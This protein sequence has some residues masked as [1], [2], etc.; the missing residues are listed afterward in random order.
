MSSAERQLEDQFI[1]KLRDLKY[2]Y[3]EDIHDRAALEANFREKFQSLNQVKL[4]DTEFQRLLDESS[5]PTSSPP[6]ARGPPVR[7]RMIWAAR[8]TRVRSVH[9]CAPTR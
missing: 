8:W 6:A 4:T 9:F 5:P 3:R 7:S 1:T 2:V